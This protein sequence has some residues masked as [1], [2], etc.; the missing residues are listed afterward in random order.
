MF[1]HLLKRLKFLALGLLIVAGLNLTPTA[2]MQQQ[3]GPYLLHPSLIPGGGGASSNASTQLTGAIGQAAL[4]SS[5]GG[6]FQLDGGF[7]PAATLCL[8]LSQSSQSFPA[9][10]GAGSVNVAGL[11]VCAWTALSNDPAFITI[12]SGDSGSGDGMVT[13][14]VAANSN[15]SN[16]V[17]TITIANQSYRVL[18]G[19]AFLDVPGGHPFYNEI[20]KLSARG[21]TLGCGDGNYCPDAVV[22]REQMAAFIIRALG[23]PD[24]PPPAA[25]RFDDVPPTHPFS[26]FIEQMALRQITLGCSSTPPLYCPSNSVSR[27]QMAAFVIRALHEPGY[28]PP[29]PT[30]Q[31]FDD[32]PPSNSFY[33]HIEEMALRGITLGCSASPPLYCP[34]TSVTRAQMAAFLV[35][36]FNL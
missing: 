23:M 16:R 34:L 30:A 25:Q 19:A 9:S 10:G 33:A 8:S 35:R 21:I 17:G 1:I 36:A 31:R 5:T 12:T 13:Y 32:V 20:G 24:P 2:F 27:E 4:G 3:G 6:S 28:I 7:W 22:S 15:P 14:S 11:T 29:P 26:A 18:Q